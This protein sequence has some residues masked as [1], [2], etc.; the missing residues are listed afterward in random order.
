MAECGHIND[1]ARS[2][3]QEHGYV[4]AVREG[5]RL[6]VSDD[7]P[8]RVNAFFVHPHHFEYYRRIGLMVAS[9]P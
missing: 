5:S 3:A 2:T 8:D 1:R 6:T 4:L 9:R 7:Y